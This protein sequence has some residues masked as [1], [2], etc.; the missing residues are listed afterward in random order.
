MWCVEFAFF[1]SS[2]NCK[3]LKE[4][5]IYMTNQVF[6][7]TKSLVAYFINFIYKLFDVICTEV[8]RSECTFNKTTFQLF[9]SSCDTMKSSIK[10]NIKAWCRCI[11][12]S[13]P[14]SFRRKVICSICKCSII[15][16]CCSDVF[17]IRVKSLFN[18]GIT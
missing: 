6:F 16:E 2:I 14:T 11:Y 7:F 15:K 10:C 9:R 17:V 18:Q 8:T 3:F 12:N 5:F 4:V 13:R 1:F